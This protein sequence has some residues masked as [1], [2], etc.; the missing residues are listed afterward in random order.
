MSFTW[1]FYT[2]SPGFTPEPRHCYRG[3]MIDVELVMSAPFTY[4]DSYNTLRKRLLNT[5]VNDT[6]QGA[7]I[8]S[9]LAVQTREVVLRVLN[10][11]LGPIFARLTPQKRSLQADICEKRNSLTIESALGNVKSQYVSAVQNLTN[12]NVPV[13]QVEL[14]RAALDSQSPVL[15]VAGKCATIL[16]LSYIEMDYHNG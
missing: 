8:E 15:R 3:P 16:L 10:T 2:G 5:I 12:Y 7:P 6:Y 9:A 13:Q 1:H 11:S 14:F 4:L